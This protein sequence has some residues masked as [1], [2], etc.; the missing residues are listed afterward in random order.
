MPLMFLVSMGSFRERGN[1]ERVLR[2]GRKHKF[3]V[4]NVEFK[5]SLRHQSEFPKWVAGS[6]GPEFIVQA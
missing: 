4:T 6:K 3:D 5:A 1:T 2:G